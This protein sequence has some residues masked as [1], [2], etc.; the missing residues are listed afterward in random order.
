MTASEFTELHL[1]N[2]D[3]AVEKFYRGH[4]MDRWGGSSGRCVF[5]RCDLRPLARNWLDILLGV[6]A[7]EF[8][9]EDGPVIFVERCY[10]VGALWFQ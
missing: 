1:Q 5:P 4:E 3:V 9:H 6:E 2:T 8:K 7:F 10:V